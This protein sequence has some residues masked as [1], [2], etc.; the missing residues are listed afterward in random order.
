MPARADAATRNA[1]DGGIMAAQALQLATATSEYGS[2]IDVVSVAAT[3]DYGSD[4]GFENLDE[5]TLLGVVL[6]DIQGSA[7]SQKSALLP[8]IE[9]EEGER[10]DEEPDVDGFVQ[11]RQPA[12]L[13]MAKPIATAHADV[14][15]SPV[16][17]RDALEVEYDERSRRAWSG[18]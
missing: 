14:Q 7:S 3:S 11:V 9:F 13:R 2:D 5:E 6:D 16:R 15:S 1:L 8:S 4:T 10:E 17:E 18:V 12:L